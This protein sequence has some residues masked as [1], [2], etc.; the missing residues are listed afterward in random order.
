MEVVDTHCHLDEEAFANERDDVIARAIAASVTRMLVVGITAESSASTVQFVE[1]HSNLSAIVGI[2]PN[3]LVA[4]TEADWASIVELA[5]HPKVVAIGETG[6][7][8]YWDHSP[9]ELQQEYFRRHIELSRQLKKPFVVHCRDAEVETLEL[10]AAYAQT[11]PLSGVMHSFAGSA[12]MARQCLSWG[13]HL[14]FSGMITYKKNEELRAIAAS[15]P[16]ERLLV[17]TDSPYLAPTP[18][19]GKRNEPAFVR[20]TLGVLA[21]LRSVTREDLAAATTANAIRL[22]GLG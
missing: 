10:L 2:H 7:D 6:L 11:G 3:Y 22:F 9:L 16:V 1:T 14:S 15:V 4:A 17:E 12:E 20:Y 18:E 19:R 5:R 13:M 21:D 8:R